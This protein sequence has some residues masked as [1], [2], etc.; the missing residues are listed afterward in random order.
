MSDPKSNRQQAVDD[1]IGSLSLSQKMDRILARVEARQQAQAADLRAAGWDRETIAELE[2]EAKQAPP[3]LLSRPA[4]GRV[5]RDV[6]ADAQLSLF[7]LERQGQ[8]TALPLD[9]Q[10]E[11]PT[12]LTRLPIFVP[13]KRTT[14]RELL[15]SDNALPFQTPWG[16]GKKYG[17]PLTVFDEDTL[18]ALGR[19]R[20]NLLIGDGH[21]FPMKV[22]AL[23]NRA[24]DLHVHALFC[25]VSQVQ[26]FCSASSGG[27]NNKLRLDSIRRLANTR[28]EFDTA[29][30]E[31]VASKGT[32]I[33][34]IEVAWQKYLDEAVL[35][36]QFS[37][38][39]AQWFEKAYSY[40]DWNVRK[41]LTDTGKALHRFLSGQGKHYT[42][43]TKKLK[44]TI[45]YPREYKEFMRDLRACLAQLQTIG[46]LKRWVIEGNGRARPHKLT[47]ER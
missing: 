43:F 24:E 5:S 15:D 21:K 27:H 8:F 46:W 30:K 13:S 36:V 35:Y 20:Q 18:I 12:I 14:Q 41:Q 40:I 11:F 28:I 19:L 42:I 10:Q 1:C 17:P 45:G 16:R 23:P 38:V 31:K 25:M 47:I 39:M 26:A 32:T 29:T 3:T 4:R 6:I 9:P 7:E 37:P 44:G 2:A 34:L 22:A 33:S